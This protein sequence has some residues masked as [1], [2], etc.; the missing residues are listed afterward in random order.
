MAVKDSKKKKKTN[1]SKNKNN[2]KKTNKKKNINKNINK[3]VKEESFTASYDKE[4]LKE[5]PITEDIDKDFCDTVSDVLSEDDFP[6]TEEHKLELDGKNEDLDIDKDFYDTVTDVLSE[7]DFLNTEEYKLELEEENNEIIEDEHIDNED[8][9]F[10]RKKK[11]KLII[12]LCLLFISIIYLFI[13]SFS[14]KGRKK[15]EI[16]YNTEYIEPGYNASFLLKDISK[17]VKVSNNL[18]NTKVGTYRITYYL[19]YKIFK[20]KKTRIVKVIDDIDP[21]INIKED[22]VMACPNKDIPDIEYSASDEYDGDI[23]NRV[24]KEVTDDKIFFSVTDK[25][26]NLFKTEVKI[27]KDDFEAPVITLKGNSTMYLNIGAKYS[28]PGYSA[29]DNCDDD[30]SDKVVVNGE[31]GTSAG[32]YT[33]TYSVTDNAGNKGEITRTI[34]VRNPNLYNNGAI[35][36]GTI[37]LTFDDGPNEGTTNVILDILR[38]EGVSATFF[39]TCNGP[40]YLINRIVNEGHTIALH[41]ASHNYAYVYSSIDN[42]FADLNTVSNRVKNLTGIDSKI[43]RFPGG[44]SNTVS[45]RYKYHIMSDLT[46]MVLD[47]GYRY[48]DW[49]VDSN[50]AGGAN[51][52]Y[53]VYS[54]VVNNLSYSRANMVLMHDVKPQTRD[55]L[56]DIIR[57][58]KNNGFR[59]EKITMDTYM[60]RHGVNN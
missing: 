58:G 2:K 19:K 43:I 25:A 13:P 26:N 15:I 4:E 39:V 48:Y 24:V 42:Y 46:S 49:N 37:Y 18:D 1:Y 11:R 22:V 20:F 29:T 52:S 45:R 14:L 6:N 54:N 21:V 10:K 51:S 56:R 50:D 59:F 53:Q 23:T 28:E 9:K 7:D 36:N 5:N 31:V 3:I 34:I 33:L 27:V 60:I 30:I 35:G 57:Y 8:F 44:S 55:A 32:T 17:Y 47:R 16:T 41:T 12:L 40:D 38:E